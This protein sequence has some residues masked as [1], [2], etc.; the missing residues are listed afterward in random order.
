M[1]QRWFKIGFNRA[2]RIMDQ[3]SD[4]DVVGEELGTMPRKI[5]MTIEDFVFLRENFD[6]ILAYYKN[7]DVCE[8]DEISLGDKECSIGQRYKYTMTMV[9]QME[10]HEFEH[11][12]AGILKKVGFV[13]VNVTP[14]SGDQGVDVLAVKD[15]IKYAIQCKNYASPLSNTPVQEVAAGKLFYNCH[16]GVVMTNST[17]TQG[18]IQLAGATNILLWDRNKLSELISEAE[19]YE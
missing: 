5:N 18:A 2:A 16:V 4:M 9:D 12:C 7:C 1:L 8:M 10:G 6:E 17:F 3:L 14:A 11:F 19:K 13:N 15:G